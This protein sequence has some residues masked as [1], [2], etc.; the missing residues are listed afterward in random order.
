MKRIGNHRPFAL[1][2][3]EPRVLLSGNALI[4]G[5]PT[6]PTGELLGLDCCQAEEARDKAANP[7]AAL[8]YDPVAQLEDIFGPGAGLPPAPPLEAAAAELGPT[9]DSGPASNEASTRNDAGTRSWLTEELLA[10]DPGQPHT[11]A[12]APA[13]GSVAAQLTE[14]LR[15]ANGPPATA[16]SQAGGGHRV[17]SPGHSPGTLPGP[18]DPPIRNEIWSGAEDPDYLWEIND[19]N[20]TE[21]ADPGWDVIRVTGELKI[22]ATADN[23]FTIQITSLTGGNAPGRAEHFD[24]GQA[25]SW[26]ILSTTTGIT[27]FSREVINLDKAGFTGAAAE[28]AFV[29]DLSGNGKD[30]ILRYLPSLP[31]VSFSQPEWVEQGPTNLTGNKNTILPPDNS[32]V[33]AVQ[34]I[35]VHPG[36][37]AIAFLGAVNGGIWWTETLNLATPTWSPLADN[38]HSLAI[39]A[40]A[41]SPFDARGDPVNAGTRRD[42]LVLYAD[43]GSFSSSSSRGG[44]AAGLFRSRD[45]G[46]TW[47]EIGNFDGLRITAI[48]PSS[49]TNGLM[50]VGTYELTTSGVN[51]GGLYRTSNGGE[52][53]ARLSGEDDLPEWRVT[54]VVQDPGEP[55]RFY[56]ALAGEAQLEDGDELDPA[57]KGIYRTDNGDADDADDISWTRIDD[58]ITPDYDHDGE[59]NEIDP[60]EDIDGNTRITPGEDRDG[61]RRLDVVNEDANGNRTLDAGEDLNGNGTLDFDEDLDHDGVLDEGEPDRNGNGL[62]D[63]LGIAETLEHALRIRLAVSRAAGNPVYAAIIGAHDKRLAGVFRSANQ[64]G[65]WTALDLPN[66]PRTNGDQGALHFAI[67]ADPTD[68]NVVYVAGD[69][70]YESP[71]AGI[72]FRWSG[73]SWLQITTTDGVRPAP[74]TTAPHADFR[75]LVFT[76]DNNAILAGTD[77]GIYRLK[78]PRGDVDSDPN[79]AVDSDPTE[80]AFIGGGLRISEVGYSVAFDRVTNTIFAGTQDNGVIAQSATGSTDWSASTGGDGNYVGVG[81]DG[82]TSTRYYMANNFRSFYRQDFTAPNNAGIRIQVALSAPGNLAVLSGL[83]G[84][85][86]FP[87]DEDT[88]AVTDANFKGFRAI[89][90]AVNRF[91]SS[92]L[93]LGRIRLYKSA[94]QGDT[95]TPFGS[96]EPKAFVTALAY[97]GRNSDG[98]ENR[99]VIY[100]ARGRSIWVSS[101]DGGSFK[102]GRPAGASR[103]TH[104]ALDPNNW[105]T[106]FAVDE[107]HVW[108]ITVADDGSVAFK[109]ATGNLGDLTG[110]F[111][112]VAVVSRGGR[113]VV[114]V[115]TRNGVYR[116]APGDLATF[117]E[118]EH[119]RAVWT[120][121]GTGLPNALVTDLQFDERDPANPNDDVLV[122]GTLGRGAWLIHDAMDA[123]LTDPALRIETGDGGQEVRLRLAVELSARPS[124]L[125]IL[126]GGTVTA[127]HP[128]ANIRKIFVHTGAGNDTLTIDSTNGEVVVPDD[129]AFDGG[130]GAT[131]E[132]AFEGP[133][134]DGLSTDSEDGV[135]IR[136]MGRQL[137]RATN[138]ENFENQTVWENF[139]EAIGNAFDAVT[140]FFRN[141]GRWLDETLDAPPLGNSLGSGLNGADWGRT[142]PVSDP[143]FGG[144]AAEGLPSFGPARTEATSFLTR[145]F[146]SGGLRLSDIGTTLTDASALQTTLDAMDD[147]AGNV[148]VTVNADN[149]TGRIIFGDPRDLENKPFRRTLGFSIPLDLDLL[150]GALT[151]SG[152]L[153]LA[154]DIEL[155]LE[156]GVDEN[157]FYVATD[158]LAADAIPRPELIIRNIRVTGDVTG[159]A[160]FGILQV[161]LTDASLALDSA[162]GVQID[163]LEP[164]DPYGRPDD[165][166]LR[167]YEFIGDLADLFDVQFAG[168]SAEPDLTLR[169]TFEVAAAEPGS[170]PIFSLPPVTLGFIWDDISN[171]TDV[172]VDVSGNPL[173]D[174]LMRFVNFNPSDLMGEFRRLVTSLGQ[175]ANVDLLNVELPFGNGYKLSDGLDFSEAFLNKIYRQI[176]DVN[177]TSSLGLGSDSL[178]QGRLSGDSTFNLVIDDV[179]S[180]PITVTAAATSD[181]TSLADLAADLNAALP[182]S[183]ASKV[184]AETVQ[185]NIRFAL[186]N[187]ASL[188]VT[189]DDTAD[190]I[191][192][193]LG[194]A[195]NQG[196][197]ELPKFPTLQSLL[198]KLEELLGVDLGINYDE[199]TKRL[200]F[201]VN[202]PYTFLEETTSFA[203]D[204]DIGLGDLADASFSGELAVTGSVTLDF[205]LGIDFS[206]GQAPKLVTSLVVPPPSSGRLT[207]ASRFTINLNDGSRSTFTL[208]ALDTSA[209]SSL[210]ELVSDLNLLLPGASFT[211]GANTSTLDDF[212][213]FTRSGNAITLVVLN[214]ADADSDGVLD[215]S[216]DTNGDGVRQV[217]L[218]QIN[219][220]AI[221]AAAN[222]PMVTE[223]GFTADAIAR[224][225]TKGVLLEGAQLSGSLTVE[226]EDLAAAARFAIFGIET[227]DIDATIDANVAFRLVNPAGGT[228][229]DLDDLLGDLANIGSYL[230]VNPT[231]NASLDLQLN[232]IA[233]QPDIFGSLLPANPQVRV[234][235]P[236]IRYLDYNSNTY[237]NTDVETNNDRGVFVT[238]PSFGPLPNFS[239]LGWTDLVIALDSLASQLDE[240]KTFSFLNE[241]L[242]L[243]NLSISQVLSYA[244]DLAETVQGLASG[245]GDT[246]DELEAQIEEL[247]GIP[248]DS[249]A[250]SVEY[251]AVE[252]VTA[253]AAGTAAEYRFN[254]SGQKNALRFTSPTDGAS[255]NGVTFKFVDDGLFTGTDGSA[256]IADYDATNKTVTIYYHATYTQAA[257]IESAINTKH[258]ADAAKMP[259]TASR[260]A[261]DAANDGAGAVHQTALKMELSY[262][263]AYGNTLPFEFN[264]GDLAELLPD[265]SPVRDLL[266][267]VASFVTVEG[268]GDL[269]VTA[270]A[271]LKLVFGLDV[272]SPCNWQ[273]FFY[274]SDY[275]GTGTGT[276]LT[277]AAAIRGTNLEF[278]AGLGAINVSV[279]NGT[280]TFDSDGIANSDGGDQDASFEVEL[281]DNNGDGRHYLRGDETFFTTE[282]I[283]IDLTAGASAVLPLYAFGGALPLGSSSDDN[284]DGYPDNDL[285]VFIPSFKRLFFPETTNASNQTTLTFPGGNNDL[286][287]TGPA[288]ALEVKI[289]DTTAAP[290]AAL[291]GSRLEVSV[292][293]VRTTANQV[294]ALALPA[295][296]S[297][298]RSSTDAANTGNGAVYADL[299]IITPDLAGLFDD[300]NPCDLIR[301]APLLLDGLDA[302]LGTIQDALSSEVLNR[303][304][305]LVGDKLN[306][307]ANFIGDFR[308]GLLADLRAKLAEVGDPIGLVQEAIY[309]A[310]G[311]P[312]LDLIVKSDG[313]EI[314]SFDDVEI[315]CDGETVT[316]KIRLKKSVAL[317]DTTDDPINFDIGIPGLGLKVDG[318]VK[319]EVGFDLKLYFG[320]SASDGFF[321]D[322]S[323]G[324][325]LRL[326]F[327]VTIP[328]LSASGELFFLQLEVSDEAD[329]HDAQG[330]A[331]DPSSFS[332]HF[333]VNLR[334]P[335]GAGNKL[336]FADM[337]SAGFD[338]EDFVDAELGATA[339]VNLDLAVSFDG[340]ARFPRL[341]AEFDLDW[342]WTLGGDSEGDLDFGFH[343][344]QID[345]G[346]FISEFIKPVLDEVKKVTEPFQPLVEILTTPIPIIS[347]LAGEPI[348]MLA[349]ARSFGYLTPGTEQFIRDLATII[350]LVN[351]S[352]FTDDGSVLVPVGSFNL[353]R[354]ALG[355]VERRDGDPNPAPQ[356]L[357]SQTSDPGAKSFLQKLEDMGF[358]FPFLEISELFKLFR[359]EAVG[360]VEYHMPVLDFSAEF[361]Q[362]IPIYPPLYVIFGGEI[363]AKIDLTFGFDTYGLLKFFNSEDKNVADI[364]DGFYVKDVNDSGDDVAEVTLSGGIYAG[365]ELNVG[366]AE[367]GVT[368]GLF[369]EIEFN[370]N[371][372]DDDGKVRVSELIA[373]AREDVR[374]IF[375]IHG[376]LYVELTAFLEIHLFITDLEFEWD[377][378]HFTLLTFEVSCPQPVLADVDG[379]GNEVTV[380]AGDPGLLTLHMGPRAADRLEG[381]TTDGA[382]AFVVTH[383]SGAPGDATG[384]SV[385]VNFNGIKQTY[386]GVKKIYADGGAGS[387]TIDLRGVLAPADSAT[388]VSGGGGN[389]TIYA[390]KGGGIYHGDDGSDTIVGHPAEDDFAGIND[391]LYGDGGADTLTGNEGN[392]TIEGGDGA[393]TIYGNDGDDT[394]RGGGGNDKIYGGA[395]IDTITGGDGADTLEGQDG[396]DSIN[397]EAGDDRIVGGL[398]DDQLLG[399]DDDDNLDGGS[400][401][402]LIVGDSGTIVSPAFPNNLSFPA[403]VTGISGT[404]ND[405]LAGGAG[406]DVLFGAGGNDKLFGGT[407]LVSGDSQVTESDGIDFLDGGDGADIVFADDAHGG[408]ATTFPGATI[409]GF[410]WFDAADESGVVNNVRDAGENGLAGVTVSL[411]RAD[412][413]LVAATTTDAD[414]EFQFVG[415]EGGDYYLVFTAPGSLTFATQ[416]VGEDDAADSDADA[417]GQTATIHVDAGQSDTTHAAGFHGTTPLLS[418]DNPSIEEGDTGL[419]TLIFT[420]TLSNPSRDLVT[421]CYETLPVSADRVRDYASVSYT[422]VF[423]PG[424]TSLTIEVPVVG[425]VIDEGDAESFLVV[426]DDAHNADLD[427]AHSFGLGTIIDDD[428]PP[429]ANVAD[430][431]QDADPV[432]ELTPLSFVVSLS[433][434]SKYTI[435]LNYLTAQIVEN[436]GTLAYDAA[437]AGTDYSNAHEL[438]FGTVTFLPGET[439]QVITV[440]TLHDTLD[441]YGERMSVTVTLDPATPTTRASIGDGSATGT[442]A[443]DDATPFVQLTPEQQT[444]VEGHAGN[445]PVTVNVSLH[446]P[447]TNALTA[448]GRPVTVT[449]N[450]SRGA[451]LIFETEGDPADAEYSFQTLTF[452]PGQTNRD[453]TVNVV[454]DTRPEP[455]I[456]GQWEHFFVNLLSA[457]NGEIDVRAD[458][459]NHATIFIQ[460]DEVP[461]PGPW[462]VQFSSANYRAN[463]ADGYAT[464]T[465][466]AAAGSRDPVAVFWTVHGTA[467]PGAD[468]P[469]PG[470]DY[471]GIWENG[472]HGTR[473]IVHFAPGETTKTFTIPIRSDGRHEADETVFLYLANPTG[474]DVRGAIET[475]VLTIVDDDPAP[476]I[477]VS[478][479]TNNSFSIVEEGAGVVTLTFDVTVT[480]TSDLPVIVDW[481]AVNG[482]AAAPGDFVPVGGTLNFGTVAGTE[483][484]TVSVTIVDDALAEEVEYLAVHL[485]ATTVQNATIADYE[486]LGY[487]FDNDPVTVTGFVFMDT[488][489]NGFFDRATEYGLADVTVTITDASGDHS[490]M[491]VAA[492]TYTLSVLLGENTVEADESTAPAG[493]IVST[494]AGNPFTFEFTNSA[495]EAPDIGFTVEPTEDVPADSIG[496]G[497]GVN[498]DTA[499]GGPG[500]D[501]LNGGGGDD[502]LVGGHWLGPGCAAT[503][504][505]PYDAQLIEESGRKNVDPV[506]LQAALGSIG[507]RVFLD[508]N[509]DGR[510]NAGEPGIANIQVNLFDEDWSLVGTTY[511]DAT[512]TYSFQ[513]LTPCNYYVQFLA[514]AGYAFTSRDAGGNAF[515]NAD[516]DADPVTGLTGLITLAAAQTV[517]N[518]D[519]GLVIVPPGSGGPWSL[520][521]NQVAYSVRETDGQAT[522]TILRTSNSFEPVGVYYTRDGTAQ[523]AA[524]SDYR[525]ARGTLSFGVGE[526]EKTFVIPVYADDLAEGY[527]T[528][529]LFLNNPTGGP[530]YGNLP[531]SVLLIFDNPLPDDD[532]VYGG[533]DDDVML[534]DY[535]FFSGGS[536][537]LLG[538]MG[539]DTLYGEDGEDA[540]YG[541]GGN[542]ALDGGTDNDVLDGG[543]DND[544]NRLDGYKNLGSDTITEAASPLGSEDNIDHSQTAGWS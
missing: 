413:T 84:T 431:V 35:A 523:T 21:G 180:D 444:V 215:G 41:V 373:N 9:A 417:T 23:K 224:S 388:Y 160:N 318:N 190:P 520:Q 244:S 251:A 493:G 275:A 462:Y 146:E 323:D 175:F 173:A 345:I 351:D 289:L 524:P 371:D 270:S 153:E 316:F 385:E 466:V 135:E 182:A 184:R 309:N 212:V 331:R 271:D 377:F 255:Y 397:G 241:P 141:V 500:N 482:N 349:L 63:P 328:D 407:L 60:N 501:L 416:N 132:L 62:P 14:T 213:R 193:E 489:G 22:N 313:S 335:V 157:G 191:F 38:L 478:D 392:D 125:E 440:A 117:S 472:L 185:G 232:H 506:P 223:V 92:R 390:S 277:L 435:T 155:R 364:F 424:V 253:G 72:A 197:L 421:V 494:S 165:N 103:I 139:L 368:G 320:I 458:N 303:D 227:S 383:I 459:L 528:V 380:G 460:D 124:T 453:I 473:Q 163:L 246:L 37:P 324:E 480:G 48:A 463:E 386:N 187:G 411:H 174:L 73:A 49:A 170:D 387:D 220:I 338:L 156:I 78:D 399:G 154:A 12:S 321:F 133:T 3:L 28:G 91:D 76:N 159:F 143:I 104:L 344:V 311:K 468:P 109:D 265:G 499:Y 457:D 40:L 315:D 426:L 446:D 479:A 374:C 83:D 495:L 128:L 189:S 88:N 127:S 236:D 15:A 456:A 433:N 89:P 216:E 292:N 531:T 207:R 272:S 11:T 515:D 535:G 245:D 336:T 151:L 149:T 198:A 307:A 250:F 415:L 59:P 130:A 306:D 540:I 403:N 65:S 188:K 273:P 221:E 252:S 394:L 297:V 488:N 337:S 80:W 179:T 485:D 71:F 419:T 513:K 75:A 208:P 209:N 269:N 196:G 410:A 498:N 510:R 30:L 44:V 389:D 302:L 438:A 239:C 261:A 308:A 355:N 228:H 369:A 350:D 381:D 543:G 264:L 119:P 2:A 47:Q 144:G 526:N 57:E 384:E 186:L 443:D 54:D 183:I 87:L 487:I 226:A 348:D 491:T 67:V 445:T 305:P 19:V 475:A 542:D 358:K 342:E 274:D 55:G 116:M 56:V 260:D 82:A 166:E 16:S 247:L 254:P 200:T 268:A 34:S 347:D 152:H 327:N 406:A 334:D 79:P 32:V 527:E 86:T 222:D 461:D 94:D 541:E 171:V 496:N 1:E 537:V 10:A 122:A 422:L 370:L 304:L 346:S 536:V 162:L 341:L 231:F 379:H 233:V 517:T 314:D 437:I 27:G 375:D 6:A 412:T 525:A 194:F 237:N 502:Y 121:F 503:G 110:Q 52:D 123:L 201:Q 167:I 263:L 281:K 219:S 172:R 530:V 96:D 441:E 140:K 114:A 206:A 298:A 238:Y 295:G 544:T 53:W 129:I 471:L 402:D 430:S 176:V 74:F 365:A 469:P 235:I 111:E 376:E 211:V 329:G 357:S 25:Y 326:D 5:P 464:I 420:V 131:D 393:D 529:L 395:D 439:E 69:A 429:V 508:S 378:G 287:F 497:G 356:N 296:W 164:A 512:G 20:G 8:G 362:S 64:G 310:L 50:F 242:P 532:L 359:G 312:G 409:G 18:D 106:V 514:P 276:G 467:T 286:V 145:L 126:I 101:D 330:N 230:D 360:L 178:D 13:A 203:Y 267:G 95:I 90:F 17:I 470:A 361:E 293:S 58:G 400:G 229:I 340:D 451:A 266:A 4:E 382:E 217:W 398:G 432:T 474:G 408:Q 354:D 285:A 476:E 448:S 423:Q 418:I 291:D 450:T 66:T 509:G 137:V 39:S 434:P 465:L 325:E 317:V 539:N 202:F 24:S 405:V 333:S 372:P 204:T 259:F 507:N 112:S 299:T 343:N 107:A 332:G 105:R 45:G 31:Y 136:Q 29:L 442:I 492:G 483:T 425:D 118:A 51:R 81:Y 192:T 282:N 401:N 519:A 243:I 214:E 436:D 352:S 391:T 257:T 428:E 454:G 169:G 120:R 278:T 102:G 290:S 294:I 300:F 93:V 234:F 322:T 363:G 455:Q 138:V 516:S 42:Q 249:L 195:N 115:G 77:G 134:N 258:A 248:A 449:L 205:T 147:I 240:F 150:N 505:D 522:I 225:V 484:Q 319:V 283:G 85:T 218:D 142:S 68:E 452:S 521:F 43:T 199:A 70:N 367:G 279:K 534:G 447:V 366:I 98:T 396:N 177:L 518:I 490:T 533:D 486:G 158:H 181:N 280:A 168:G 284:G 97:G 414:G 210:D 477:T 113:L 301:N 161:K 26:R 100:V 148:T 46:D 262:R 353:Q 288:S 108:L 511:T 33:G 427:P 61:D 481:D 504:A 36:N 256:T 339:E 7:D 404:G 99:G 538:G